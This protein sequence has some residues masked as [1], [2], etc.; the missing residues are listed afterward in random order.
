MLV[1]ALCAALVGCSEPARGV[2]RKAVAA[3]AGSQSWHEKHGWKAADFFTDPQAVALCEAIQA[4]DLER[5]RQ[6]IAAGADVNARGKGN[7]TPLLWSFFDDKPER[8]Q[9]LLEAGADPNVYTE[10][11]FGLP[12]AMVAGDSVTHMACR[13]HFGHFWPVF[14]HGGDPNLPSR[15]GA[16]AGQTPVY[17]V[18]TSAAGDKKER[19]TCLAKKGASMNRAAGVGSSPLVTAEGHFG[20]YDLCL[21]LLDLGADPHAYEGNELTKITHLLCGRL[22]QQRR[23]IGQLRDASPEQMAT[24]NR[25]VERLEAMGESM[26]AAEADRQRWGKARDLIH[27]GE[28]R[29]K[30]REERKRREREAAA[31]KPA[32]PDAAEAAPPP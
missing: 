18:I 4:N 22:E 32:A 17:T 27:L 24:F 5:M 16:F 29:R 25:L 6:L 3:A 31:E 12:Q 8:F 10:S 28:M 13:S 1:V 19:I 14:E 23:G 11:D 15:A 21:L 26:A 9:L 20:R 2:L 30:E 7:M